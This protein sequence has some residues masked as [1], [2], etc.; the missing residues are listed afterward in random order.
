ML[1]ERMHSEQRWENQ[2][3]AGWSVDDPETLWTTLPSEAL[4]SILMASAGGSGLMQGPTF[5]SPEFAHKE[6]K[7][8]RERFLERIAALAA[9]AGRPS[10]LPG[11]PAG[12]PATPNRTRPEPTGRAHNPSARAGCHLW[13][14]PS[15]RCSERSAV[16]ELDEVG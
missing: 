16:I 11:Q 9:W 4:G 6:R 3:A 13:S 12:Q 5:A 8:R 10:A 1:F 14:S 7:T 2:P 15:Q